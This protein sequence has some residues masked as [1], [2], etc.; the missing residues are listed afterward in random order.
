MFVFVW[1]GDGSEPLGAMTTTPTLIELA[2]AGW[3][4][5][6]ICHITV[7]EIFVWSL[8]CIVL[9]GE[10]KVNVSSALSFIKLLFQYKQSE[11][12]IRLTK[13]ML[14]VLSVSMT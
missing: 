9:T 12:C 11:T 10:N 7:T 2:I 13:E 5:F 8:K 3:S 14:Q 1:E 4:L 6:Y